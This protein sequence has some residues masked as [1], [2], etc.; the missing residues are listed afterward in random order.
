MFKELV[1]KMSGSKR[2]RL[3]L[4]EVREALP[5]FKQF[6][7]LEV[8]ELNILNWEGL[9]VPENEPYKFGAFKVEINFPSKYS[10]LKYREI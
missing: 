2:I 7:N 6:R 10:N 3:E 5:N 9:I 8:N 1:L 4:E